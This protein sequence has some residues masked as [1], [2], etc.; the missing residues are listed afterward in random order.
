M[1]TTTH[2]EIWNF[3]TSCIVLTETSQQDSKCNKMSGMKVVSCLEFWQ[4]KISCLGE[5]FTINLSCLA[6][7]YFGGE[8]KRELLKK[9]TESREA[10]MYTISKVIT[11]RIK[12][13]N[14]IWFLPHLSL[15]MS[16][17]YKWIQHASMVCKVQSYYILHKE[18]LQS[19]TCH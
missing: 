7:P 12:P 5:L 3:F 16:V 19:E 13:T 1:R 9:W 2:E 15:S 14:L 6:W 18:P 17:I 10:L 8:K 4:I 11:S